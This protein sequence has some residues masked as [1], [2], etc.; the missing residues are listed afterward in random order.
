MIETA[1]ASRGYSGGFGAD[2]MLK[3]L[4]LAADAARS[5]RQPLLLGALA[6][7]IYQAMSQ[8]GDGQLDFSGVIRQYLSQQERAA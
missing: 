5:V 3:D 4:G 8:A 7:Q 1:P 6:Q 2:L